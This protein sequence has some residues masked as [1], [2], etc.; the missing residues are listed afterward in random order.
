MA[1]TYN[2][3]V[4]MI[5]DFM[6]MS[7]VANDK[8]QPMKR[9]TDSL[10]LQYQILENLPVAQ[11]DRVSQ[12]YAKLH[13]IYKLNSADL[14]VNHTPATVSTVPVTAVP[15]STVP[16][17]TVPVS[18]VPMPA[19]RTSNVPVQTA[20]TSTAV[21]V[22]AV[23]TTRV[24]TAP[25]S[26]TDN[27]PSIAQETVQTIN[28]V[29]P[30]YAPPNQPNVV[31]PRNAI[32]RQAPVTQPRAVQP[33]QPGYVQSTRP[34]HIQP[35]VPIQS[36]QSVQSAQPDR[37]NEEPNRF[38]VI[39]GDSTNSV[40]QGAYDVWNQ[41]ES[42]A[43]QRVVLRKY[44]VTQDRSHIDRLRDRLSLDVSSLPM[45]YKV[46]LTSG[47]PK[48]VRFAHPITLANLQEFNNI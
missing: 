26:Q 33:A 16:V 42:S 2:N 40:S 39:L 45:V 27:A 31:Q 5:M 7:I 23:S 20:P 32:F 13:K 30:F 36:V 24:T 8:S 1:N 4:E 22:A 29:R 28:G 25:V 9:R 19:V 21:P 43:P 41:F 10:D 6:K 3:D 46:D 48:V 34:V 35:T 37:T 47:T 38:I 15:A 44:D 18:T 11:S 12:I 14:R 17:S